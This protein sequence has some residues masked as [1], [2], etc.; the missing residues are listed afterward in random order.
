MRFSCEQ[1]IWEDSLSVIQVKVEDNSEYYQDQLVKFYSAFYRT[2][3][4]PTAYTEQGGWY[5]GFDQQLHNVNET[6]NGPTNFYSDMSIWDTFRTEYPWL[7]LMKPDVMTD[8][9][10]SMLIVYQVAGFLPKWPLA[11]GTDLNV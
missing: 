1:D 7:V 10:K 8:M 4:A 11:F 9:I 6:K 2:V 3:L 5:I